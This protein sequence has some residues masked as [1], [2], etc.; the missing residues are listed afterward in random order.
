MKKAT[1]DDRLTA[2]VLDWAFWGIL[3]LILYFLVR[4]LTENATI[5]AV[6]STPFA[7][8][9]LIKD[10]AGNGIGKT[11]M[12]LVI[13]DR[14]TKRPVANPVILL[15]RNLTLT[16]WFIDI[17]MLFLDP[18]SRRLGERLTGTEVVKT[19]RKKRRSSGE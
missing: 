10:L 1:L 13:V 18:E 8:W 14:N 19:F 5:I 16:I 4:A 17:P 11:K 2:F 9:L 7:A 12:N 15:I 6:S 3:G